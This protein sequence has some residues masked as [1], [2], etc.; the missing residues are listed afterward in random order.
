MR[1]D[2]PYAVARPEDVKWFALRA[3]A[4]SCV[5]SLAG[6]APWYLVGKFVD[7]SPVKEATARFTTNTDAMELLFWGFVVFAPIT[8]ALGAFLMSLWRLCG[9]MAMLHE[10]KTPDL[11]KIADLLQADLEGVEPIRAAISQ[12][13]PLRYRDLLYVESR[14]EAFERAAALATVK[15]KATFDGQ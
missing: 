9:E 6:L 3:Y 12:G 10:L 5:T 8:F 4:V 14:A 11:K 13:I 15:M 2:K 7:L 1:L